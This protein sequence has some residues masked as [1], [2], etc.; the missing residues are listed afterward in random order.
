MKDIDIQRVIDQTDIIR[1]INGFWFSVDTRDYE[2]MRSYLTEQVNFDYSALFGTSMPPTADELVEEVRLN[3]SGLRSIQH[4][5]TNH[6]VKING[7]I[8]QCVAN[9][10]AQ[11]F[12]PN[13]RGGNFWTLGGRYT[14]NLQR[15]QDGWKIHGCV[16]SVS[17]TDGNLQIF[18]LAHEQAR[19]AA[20][21]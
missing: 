20:S 12:L 11:H 5:T 21:S 18:E 8:A 19:A 6:Y 7:D 3:H 16:I 17:W 4:I 13:D 1:T 10:L 14:F 15:T 9:F 2:T